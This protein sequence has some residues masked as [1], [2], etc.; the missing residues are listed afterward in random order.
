MSNIRNI[1]L[2]YHIFF[3]FHIIVLNACRMQIWCSHSGYTRS[4]ALQ[5][6]LQICRLPCHKGPYFTPKHH[7]KMLGLSLKFTKTVGCW[8]FASDHTWGAYDAPPDPVGSINHALDRASA[9]SSPLLKHLRR[10][11][12]H[13]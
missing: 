5:T 4:I 12:P 7:Q 11:P 8:V 2:N 9:P 10:V 13:F 6:H 3:S 1:E